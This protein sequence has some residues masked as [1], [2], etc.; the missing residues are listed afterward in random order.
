M[1]TPGQM[2]DVFQVKSF[3]HL[4]SSGHKLWECVCTSCGYVAVYP[5]YKLRKHPQCFRCRTDRRHYQPEYYDMPEFNSYVSMINRCTVPTSK[6]YPMY[7]GRGITVCDEWLNSFEQFLKDMGPRPEGQT[8][9]RIDY[10]RGYNPENCRWA[11][12]KVQG[13]NKRFRT[14]S[15]LHKIHFPSS[16]VTK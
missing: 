12:L 13:K 4:D 9:D 16:E 6:S 8:L 2:F 5:S 11:T 14:Q 3:S 10:N 7:G 15:L 1:I